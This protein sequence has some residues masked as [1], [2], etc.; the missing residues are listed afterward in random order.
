MGRAGRKGDGVEPLASCIRLRFMVGGKRY[1]ETIDLAPTAANIKAVKR[2]AADIRSKIRAGNFVYKEFFPDSPNRLSTGTVWTFDAY[3]KEWLQTITVAKSTR[4]SYES[5]VNGFWCKALRDRPIKDLKH[6]DLAKVLV[7]KAKTVTAKTINNY[8][9]PLRM[10]FQVALAEEVILRDPTVLLKN[11]KAQ[12]P[13]PDPFTLEELNQILV[14]MREHYPEQVVNYYEFAF[15]TGLRPSEQIAVRWTDISW[16]RKTIRIERANVMGEEKDTKTHT[17]R[18]VDLCDRAIA[19]LQRQRKHT[20][21][22]GTDVEIFDNPLTGKAWADDQSQRRGY[23][24]PALRAL[25]IRKRDAYQCRHTFATLALMGGA[26]PSYIA[27]QLGHA[28]TEMLFKHYS[29]WVDGQDFGRERNRVNDVFAHDLPTAGKKANE[30][31]GL[32][33]EGMGFETKTEVIDG[34]QEYKDQALTKLSVP[35]K[36]PEYFNLPTTLPTRKPRALERKPP[37]NRK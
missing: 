24:H 18:E 8:L 21:M 13:E 27:R 32:V 6:M 29:R 35:S 22:K 11:R 31:N 37:S 16:N 2:V 4:Q 14:Y 10:I 1:T 34:T 30:N 17:I 20:F 7:E 9:I 36:T 19:A 15:T 3:A 12:R 26:N 23:F 28:T 33:A 25:G 5:A